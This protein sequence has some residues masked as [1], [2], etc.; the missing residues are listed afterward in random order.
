MADTKEIIIE[1]A[2]AAFC[3]NGYHQTKIDDIAEKAA[4]A[5]GTI[6]YNFS[7]KAILFAEVVTTGIDLLIKKAK[8]NTGKEMTA[9]AR[10]AVLIETT[11]EIYL[12]YENI[13]RVVINESG[14]ESVSGIDQEA[15]DRIKEARNDYL[16]LITQIIEDGVEYNEFKE[17]NIDLTAHVLVGVIESSLNCY[18]NKQRNSVSR[19]QLFEMI[20]EIFFRGI[21]Q[22]GV[23]ASG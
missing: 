6:Y 12:Q 4:V 22:T 2:A 8:K 14:N 16:Q 10:L 18:W 19:Q 17:I 20:S 7:S 11:V 9:R 1:S 23:E 21:L 3:E 15:I 13:S 5:K